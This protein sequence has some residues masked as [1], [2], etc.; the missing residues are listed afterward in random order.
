MLDAML[1]ALHSQ[2]H[3]IPAQAL[4]SGYY[5]CV[6]ITTADIEA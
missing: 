4:F 3:L 2:S 5:Y 1:N 6:P